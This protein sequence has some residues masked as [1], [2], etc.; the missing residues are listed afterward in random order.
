MNT[1]YLRL[2]LAFLIANFVV[3]G[4]SIVGT[5]VLLDDK[6]TADKTFN[7]R[8][9]QT[10]FR[11]TY[12]TNGLSG[13][14]ELAATKSNSAVRY[15]VLVD[16]K[17]DV[18]GPHGPVLRFVKQLDLE[19]ISSVQ[20]P[21]PN[22]V[23]WSLPV[24]TSSSGKPITVVAH[25][26][27]GSSA[28]RRSRPGRPGPD[29]PGARKTSQD[30]DSSRPRPRGKGSGSKRS[31]KSSWLSTANGKTFALYL[32]LLIVGIALAG[33]FVARSLT[34]PLRSVQTTINRFANGDL[35]AR[36]GEHLTS[37]G[38]DMGHL[39]GDFDRMANGVEKMIQSRDRLL[40]QL[41]HEMRSPLARLR[42]A[43]EL[44]RGK[45]EGDETYLAK[46]DREIDRLNALMDEMLQLARSERLPNER[47]SQTLSLDELI[48]ESIERTGLAAEERQISVHHDGETNI[49]FQGQGDLLKRAFD[50]V[51]GNAVKFSPVGGR[52]D[53]ST[54]RTDADVTIRIADQGPGVP[55]SELT[56]LFEPFYRASNTSEDGY[57][58]GLA[59]VASAL[60]AHNGRAHATLGAD[61]GLV[62]TL[63]IP[64]TR[65]PT[66]N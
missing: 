10:E 47:Q 62:V 57:G 19:S 56:D 30:F 64:I 45:N 51:I 41:S 9:A 3:L 13:V 16:G 36:V 25:E 7:P 61:G 58:L 5:R 22:E 43:I 28:G 17:T 59:I 4:I 60:R 48:D 42:F 21:P 1:F 46:A 53:I 63:Q 31:G 26:F 20:L 23:L 52:I 44:A 15:H 55:A 2:L 34:A 37:R 12:K 27:P 38:D 8:T 54:S 6:S 14:E 24:A 65:A 29:G 35:S 33:W 40:H 11:G 50:N 39:A 49:R 32:G 66:N 18:S